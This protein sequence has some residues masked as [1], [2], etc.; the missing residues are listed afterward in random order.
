MVS[1]IR[2]QP[3]AALRFRLTQLVWVLGLVL[4]SPRA[5]AMA[6]M[7]DPSGASVAAP[8]PAP[9]SHT[10]DLVAPKGCPDLDDS[11]FV[12]PPRTGEKS[13]AVQPPLD[14]PDRVLPTLSPLPSLHGTRTPRPEGE[15]TLPRP[16]HGDP[17]FRP[18]RG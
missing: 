4:M 2:I 3:N 9:P 10:G 12:A 14:P 16:G 15:T 11:G 1:S 7:C 18:P 5:F 6:P 8:A 13:P 17:V